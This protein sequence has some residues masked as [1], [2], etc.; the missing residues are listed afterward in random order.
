MELTGQN[1]IAG[2]IGGDEYACMI[3]YPGQDDGEKMRLEIYRRFESFNAGS[4]KVYNVTVSVG[5]SI[6]E[7]DGTLNLEDALARADDRL[8]LEKQYRKKEVAK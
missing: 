5:T 1:G 6:V 3:E 8:Y 2:R 4:D 7:P